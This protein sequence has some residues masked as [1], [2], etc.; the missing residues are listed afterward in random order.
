MELYSTLVESK[1]GNAWI[2]TCGNEEKNKASIYYTSDVPV[3]I[4]IVVKNNIVFCV[5]IN[6]NDN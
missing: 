3:K 2:S 1:H 4:D 5:A 6:E